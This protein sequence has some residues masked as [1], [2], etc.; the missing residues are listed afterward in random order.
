MVVGVAEF[1]KC[2]L[3]IDCK[4]AMTVEAAVAE[5]LVAVGWF[6]EL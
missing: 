5:C 2:L 1:G 4:M 3:M 6:W